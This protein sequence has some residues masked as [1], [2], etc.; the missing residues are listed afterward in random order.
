MR[1]NRVHLY[2]DLIRLL[3]LITSVADWTVPQTSVLF[4]PGVWPGG[5]PVAFYLGRYAMTCS[6]GCLAAGCHDGATSRKFP[7]WCRRSRA[8]I[9]EADVLD[10]YLKFLRFVLPVTVRYHHMRVVEQTIGGLFCKPLT[11]VDLTSQFVMK[12]GAW[13]PGDCFF[14]TGC[15]I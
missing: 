14:D 5:V 1:L 6:S 9:P 12:A 10:D 11:T 15:G 3:D 8:I 4:L 2:S 7:E 13:R